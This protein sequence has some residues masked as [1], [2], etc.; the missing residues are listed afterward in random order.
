MFGNWG[1]LHHNLPM[2]ATEK[3]RKILSELSPNLVT[4]SPQLPMK[5][6]TPSPLPGGGTELCDVE[7]RSPPGRGRGGFMAREQVREEQK[8]SQEHDGRAALPRSRSAVESAAQRHRPATGRWELC[9]T[10][11]RSLCPVCFPREIDKASNKVSDKSGENRISGVAGTRR[12]GDRRS[13]PQICRT[14]LGTR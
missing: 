13:A 3:W 7:R 12:V 11:C 5:Q 4:G 6:P 9:P 10:I 14:V 1:G 2:R 8:A